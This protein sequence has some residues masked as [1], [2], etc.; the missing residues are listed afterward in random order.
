MLD[1]A[2]HRFDISATPASD[3]Q[4]TLT[5][6]VV[7]GNLERRREVSNILEALCVDVIPCSTLGQ[8]AQLLALQRPHLIFCD[9][10]LPDGG[11]ADVL[12][13]KLSGNHLP[14]IVVLTRNWE[15]EFYIN[16]TQ[17]GAFDVI[18]SPWCPTDIELSFI[19][20]IREEKQHR[21]AATAR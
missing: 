17:R 9:E 5:I 10:Q 1:S 20:G 21:I 15:W 3:L 6:L 19:R 2:A 12:E 4:E 7:S 8:A 14:P 13:L 11:Y 16:A 18:R